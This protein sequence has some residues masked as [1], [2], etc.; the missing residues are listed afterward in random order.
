MIRA[1]KDIQVGPEGKV[2]KQGEQVTIIR[3]PKGMYLQ[4]G[5]DGQILAVRNRME[6]ESFGELK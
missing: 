1:N 4:R 3:T 6:A 2:I 5:S